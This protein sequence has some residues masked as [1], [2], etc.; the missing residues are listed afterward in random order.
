[1]WAIAVHDLGL[2]SEQFFSLTLP[3]FNALVE[4]YE[5]Q[6]QREDFRAAQICTV[7]ANIM[8]KKQDGTAFQPG[9]FFPSLKEAKTEEA[10]EM[11][12]EQILS[13][14]ETL[15]PRPGRMN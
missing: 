14:L 2:S 15:Y 13:M 7:A 6:Q 8:G 10:R 9:D 4:R 5:L 1:M 11:S 3:R 12:G